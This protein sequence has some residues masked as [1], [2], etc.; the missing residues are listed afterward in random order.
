MTTQTPSN[1]ARSTK[2]V[3]W[4]ARSMVCGDFNGDGVP[5]QAVLGYR[6]RTLLL[7]VRRGGRQAFQILEFAIGGA[8]QQGVCS[9]PVTL[10]A[11]DLV[12]DTEDGPLSGCKAGKGVKALSI[13]DGNCDPINLYWSHEADEM[14]WWRN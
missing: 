12:C 3:R 13:E 4:D 9:L 10:R 14:L 2:D 6:D 1:L 7:A 11:T 8:S 5:D